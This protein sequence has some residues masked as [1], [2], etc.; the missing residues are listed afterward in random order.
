M[1]AFVD[2]EIE[3]RYLIQKTFPQL[4]AYALQRN[5]ELRIYDLSYPPANAASAATGAV[6]DFDDHSQVVL[7]TRLLESLQRNGDNFVFLVRH[8]PHTIER[9]VLFFMYVAVISPVT[10]TSFMQLVAVSFK[11]LII[12]IFSF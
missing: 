8:E 12:M 4:K 9:K 7:P 3:R 5:R 11:R 2:T 1:L 6:S 10:L